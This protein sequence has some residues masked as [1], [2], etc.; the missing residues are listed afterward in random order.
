[1]L[2]SSPCLSSQSAASCGRY[3]YGKIHLG[4][5]GRKAEV[6]EILA[7]ADALK[8][9]IGADLP[10]ADR[11]VERLSA[12]A[13]LGTVAPKSVF[14]GLLLV[15]VG[16]RAGERRSHAA[17]CRCPAGDRGRRASGLDGRERSG[18]GGLQASPS[19]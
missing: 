17:D 12:F 10:V 13:Q 1:M 6:K 2:R 16:Q 9:A 15:P 8:V 18:G 5:Y 7:D 19:W 3:L 11:V 14:T 4:L